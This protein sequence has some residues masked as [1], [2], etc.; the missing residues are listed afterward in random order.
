[1]DISSKR[2]YTKRKVGDVVNGCE[3][4]ERVN[5]RLWR[6]R[7]SC[8]EYFTTQPSHT[9]GKCRKCAYQE[10]SR[11]RTI[12]GESPK[13]GK[14]NASR[15]YDI[16]LGMK[17]RCYNKKHHDYHCYGGRGIKICDEWRENYLSFKKWAMSHG[18][19]QTLTIDR[20][21]VNGN[22][23]PSNCRW[24]TRYEQSLNRRKV[25]KNESLFTFG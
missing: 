10:L 12:H 24:A 1:M 8:G 9:K 3:L 20:V 13:S 17:T 19:E 23:E 6:V 2:Q 16:W 15:L 22:Y 11:A 18:Y 5:T 21:D 4:I 25:V 7:C 14:K